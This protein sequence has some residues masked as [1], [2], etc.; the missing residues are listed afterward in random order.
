MRLFQ[1]LVGRLTAVTL[2]VAAVITVA[3]AV[4]VYALTYSDIEEYWIDRLEEK[5]AAR[6]TI[7]ESIFATLEASL[8]QTRQNY[9]QVVKDF[10]PGDS[11]ADFDLLVPPHGDG[12][13]RTTDSA[14]EGM[15]LGNGRSISKT[16]AF[17][18]STG[19]MTEQRRTRFMAAFSM[20]TTFGPAFRS[21]VPNFWFFNYHGD[22][23]IFAPDREDQLRPYRFGL[24]HN[25]NFLDQPVALLAR[26]EVNPSRKM[27]CQRLSPMVYDAKGAAPVLMSSCQIPVD[28]A[29]GNHIGSFGT[30]LP[31][32][33][34]MN[35]TVGTT[36]DDTFRLMLVSTEFGLLAHTELDTGGSAGD[37]QKTAQAERLDRIIPILDGERGM[38]MH[39]AT[40]SIV[41]F[42]RINGPDWYL[43]MVQPK[44]DV[45][46]MAA[47]GAIR[48][49]AA[50]SLTALGL[51]LVVGF[52]AYRLIARPLRR[53]AETANKSLTS[54]GSVQALLSRQDEI[55]Q[56]AGALR[57]RDHRVE[58]LVETLEQRV[59]ERTAELDHA[60]S[61][62]ETANQAKTAFLATM[63][64]EIR[65]PMNGVM[66]MSEAL[67]RT[68]LDEEQREYLGVMNRSG[69]AL[70]SLI[71]DILD[72]SKIEAGKLKLDPLPVQPVDLIEEVCGLYQ[73]LANKKGLTLL[74]DTSGIDAEFIH[75]DP[76]RLRQI[77]SNLVSNALKFTSEGTVA[78][79]ATLQGD[80]PLIVHVQDTGPGIAR[81]VQRTIFNKF[82]QAEQS[83]TRRFGGTG[84]GL[85]ISRELAQLL[86]G[87]LTVASVQGLGSTFTV[88][89]QAHRVD[90]EESPT[91]VRPAA[92]APADEDAVQ[93]MRVLV[94]EDLAVNQQVLTAICRPLGLTLVMAEN[95]RIAIDLLKQE[96]FDA[97]L[98]DLR[99]PVMDGLEATRRI[100]AGE[101]GEW[102]RSIPIIA[103]SAN[104]MHEHVEESREA[105]AD[106][107]VAKP[108]SRTALVNALK[109]HFHNL[110]E[111]EPQA[112]A[113]Y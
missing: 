58:T 1:S 94:A 62:A 70:L 27:R 52:L 69:E 51:T 104:A 45:A 47:M 71:D 66:G 78:V 8:E 64:H 6:A 60:K 30:T 43:V 81:K 91:I 100:R 68:T 79:T 82:E 39:E 12:S 111:A 72:I 3:V 80:G 22:L 44:R 14:Y 63:S 113:P 84:L 93:G 109:Q 105:G 49:A 112:A 46:S 24:P 19:D 15:S 107:H 99:M 38:L 50:A 85:A 61:E 2:A 21:F 4:L 20:V 103:L 35:E 96:K 67:A 11:Q 95:G 89:I 76:L 55:G 74:R 86:G 56:L 16:A 37:V 87:D 106:D 36:E 73:E 53:L 92:P 41:T 40:D 48:S 23:V 5:T 17:V 88:T 13:R 33:G 31:L 7:Q 65:T 97:V 102:A 101:A 26:P 110:E 90:A 10:Q 98:M 42:S 29:D 34:W 57:E 18:P 54:D 77:L 9:W 108:V 32:T 75:T 25:F 83:T 59:D 28:D